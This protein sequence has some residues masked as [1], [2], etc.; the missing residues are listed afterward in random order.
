MK[1]QF[2]IIRQIKSL[3]EVL[4]LQNNTLGEQRSVISIKPLPRENGEKLIPPSFIS[5]NI[6]IQDKFSMS[7]FCAQIFPH[8]FR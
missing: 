1:K 2:F 5:K 7:Q 4:S 8:D 6:S 3:F